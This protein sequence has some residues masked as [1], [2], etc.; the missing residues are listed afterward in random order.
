MV[1]NGECV[2]RVVIQIPNCLENVNGVCTQ[3]IEGYF[4]KNNACSAVPITCATYNRSTGKCTSC[5]VGHFFQ[6]DECIFP[7]LSDPNCIYYESAYCSRC[8]VGYYLDNYL[9]SAVVKECLNFDY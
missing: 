3:C 8:R 7:A 5:I 6:N 9:C 2:I 4:V 1:S